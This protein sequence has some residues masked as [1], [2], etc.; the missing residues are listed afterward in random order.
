VAKATEQQLQHCGNLIRLKL[1]E[2]LFHK[3][4][5]FVVRVTLELKPKF[6][7][8]WQTLPNKF[9]AKL[10]TLSIVKYSLDVSFVALLLV[11]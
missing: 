10:H 9:V 5:D 6:Q 2:L 4:S 1:S 11:L 3:G 7:S 8:P